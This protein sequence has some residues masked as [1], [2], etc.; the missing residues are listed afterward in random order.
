MSHG[1]DQYVYKDMKN[2]FLNIA[3]HS[4]L[5]ANHNACGGD[6]DNSQFSEY[7]SEVESSSESDT[8]YIRVPTD[9]HTK[10]RRMS[11][12][13]QADKRLSTQRKYIFMSADD[14]KSEKYL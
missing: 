11:I 2:I 1:D 5:L 3:A 8:E 10:F 9:S 4:K 7:E 12:Y 6:D 13:S 14:I